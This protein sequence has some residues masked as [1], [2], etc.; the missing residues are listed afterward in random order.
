MILWAVDDDGHCHFCDVRLLG[1]PALWQY[2]GSIVPP[3]PTDGALFT[4]TGTGIK[5]QMIQ[6][7]PGE[8]VSSGAPIMDP[9]TPAEM[10]V[11]QALAR[12][13]GEAAAALKFVELR[14]PDADLMLRLAGDRL[15]EALKMLPEPPPSL[16]GSPIV[17][18]GEDR[19]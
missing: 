4:A 5:L 19:R 7:A 15:A 1:G 16:C 14:R 13:I 11:A 2:G 10:A 17:P 18:T 3:W 12:K 6:G 8:V 9:R